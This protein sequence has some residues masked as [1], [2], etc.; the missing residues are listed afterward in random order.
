MSDR[1]AFLDAGDR[2]KI[3]RFGPFVIKRPCP[4]ALWPKGKAIKTDAAFTREE[5]WSFSGS[6]PSSWEV[7]HFGVRFKIKLTEF[8]HLGLFPEH[9]TLWDWARKRCKKGVR[10]LNLFAYSGGFS[11]AAAQEGAE[12][13]HVDAS[14]GMVSWARE[15]ARL[16]GLE[17]API[18]WIVDDGI[19]FLKKE[20]KRGSFYD[21]IVLDPPTFGRGSKKEVFKIEE[22]LY[23]MME[24]LAK[25]LSKRPNF[26]ILSCHTPGFTPLFLGEVLKRSLKKKTVEMKEMTLGSSIPA[27]GFARWNA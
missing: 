25:L 11:I 20:L 19:K 22:D 1:Y 7:E 6:L 14:K 8:G 13:C 27:G 5:R 26:V 4:L 9:G 2:E 15:N 24:L 3:E 17:K 12:V 16:N 18:R 21:A 10:L 23:P